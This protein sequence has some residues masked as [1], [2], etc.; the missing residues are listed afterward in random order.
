MDATSA[1]SSLACGKEEEVCAY[2]TIGRQNM[3]Q[4][5]DVFASLGFGDP[6]PGMDLGDSKTKKVLYLPPLSFIDV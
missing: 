5:R 2:E 6:Y 4:N 1:S 3:I